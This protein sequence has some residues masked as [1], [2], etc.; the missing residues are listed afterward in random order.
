M[1]FIARFFW[2]INRLIFTVDIDP[3][4]K[5]SGGFLIIHGM[6]IVIGENVQILGQ[7]KLYHGTTL[8]GNNFKNKIYNDKEINQPIIKNN[9][10]IGIN[11]S[12]L[13]PCI[14]EENAVIGTG[15]IVTKDV[16]A[17]STVVGVNGRL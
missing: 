12:I 4:A 10:V 14:I 13:G 17:G 8:G 9:V 3:R 5:I 16:L 11:S 15:A 7:V 6:S 2:L 1:Q